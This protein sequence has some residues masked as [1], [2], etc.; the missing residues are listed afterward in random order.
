MSVS[1]QKNGK[2]P[3][4]Q[5]STRIGMSQYLD[6]NPTTK[7]ETHK[8]EILSKE[9]ERETVRKGG[10]RSKEWTGKVLVVLIF[11]ICSDMTRID[12]KKECNSVGLYCWARGKVEREGDHFRVTLKQNASKEWERI[13]TSKVSAW[14]RRRGWRVC[15]ANAATNLRRS[16]RVNGGKERQEQVSIRTGKARG[17]SCP[18]QLDNHIANGG[19]NQTEGG[20]SRNEDEPVNKSRA[21]NDSGRK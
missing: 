16:A 20:G 2:A 9:I 8:L 5:T 4:P 11:G 21:D 17:P 14:V 6:R 15:I 19:N 3:Y 12:F 13:E 7:N 1:Q 18:K 10:W